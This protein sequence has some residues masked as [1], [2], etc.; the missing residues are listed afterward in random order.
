[1]I[2]LPVVERLPGLHRSRAT[3]LEHQG[4]TP[5][6]AAFLPLVLEHS[7][8]FVE[9]QYCAFAG[10]THGQK[11]HDFLRRLTGSGLARE[12]RPGALHRGRLYHV[13]HKRLYATIGEP[14]NRNRRTAPIGALAARRPTSRMPGRSP[15]PEPG[16]LTPHPL[17]RSSTAGL[18]GLQGTS[19]PDLT[20]A[21]TS[22]VRGV[23][24]IACDDATSPPCSDP[25]ASTGVARVNQKHGVCTS[26]RAC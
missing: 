21:R 7:G 20:L 25:R 12:G 5:K 1:M 11:T 24:R 9:R 14:D 22:T 2:D 8:V 3:S 26:R 17:G 15:A 18:D 13:H 10:V 6:Q 4:F 19:A 23:R 16:T